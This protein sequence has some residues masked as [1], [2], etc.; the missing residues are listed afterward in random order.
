[1]VGLDAS[2][3]GETISHRSFEELRRIRAEDD[4]VLDELEQESELGYGDEM[5]LPLIAALGALGEAALQDIPLGIHSSK[6][7][8]VDAKGIFFAFRVAERVLW[9]VYPLTMANDQNAD[10]ASVIKTS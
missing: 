6:A 2:V 1:T 10:H 9:R 8:P 3:L 7:S 4:G 5:R